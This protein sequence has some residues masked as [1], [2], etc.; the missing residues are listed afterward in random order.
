[1]TGMAGSEL[2]HLLNLTRA[3]LGSEPQGAAKPD[4]PGGGPKAEGRGEAADGLIRAT[5]SA[6]GEITSIDLAPRAMRMSSEEIGEH[7]ATAVNA[8]FGDL[9]AGP[10]ALPDAAATERLT[11]QARELQDMSMRQ[12]R[13]MTQSISDL[14]A[15]LHGGRR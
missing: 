11:A 12:M 1:M 14:M 7:V 13:Q 4:Q 15:Q 6:D 8:A 10:A 3:V 9:R 2:E 5:V